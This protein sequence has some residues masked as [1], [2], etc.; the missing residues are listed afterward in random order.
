MSRRRLL[1][2]CLFLAF[3][4]SGSSGNGRGDDPPGPTAA[5]GAEPDPALTVVL[6][7]AQWERLPAVL[8]EL[9][10]RRPE[11]G[12]VYLA[13]PSVFSSP[14]A[15]VRFFG[16]RVGFA[17]PERVPGLD[18]KAPI[19]LAAFVPID[20]VEAQGAALVAAVAKKAPLAPSGVRHRLRLP[21]TDAKA[22]AAALE[23][24]LVAT[25][26]D[27]DGRAL[28]S[29]APGI[30]ADEARM[31]R[32]AAGAGAVDLTIVTGYG[33]AGL[34][35][36]A[37]D[38][39]LGAAGGPGAFHPLVADPTPSIARVHLRLDRFGPTGGSLGM[40]M[41]AR[42][43]FTMDDAFL[44]PAM[45]QG[46]AE[47]LTAPLF[48]DPTAAVTTDVIAD[49]PASPTSAPALY[50][51]L[52]ERGAT[53]LRADPGLAGGKPVALRT[54]DLPAI[55]AGAPLPPVIEA[56]GSLDGVVRLI[57]ECGYMCTLY[58]G[59]GNGLGLVRMAEAATPGI[60]KQGLAEASSMVPLLAN[61]QLTLAGSV[62]VV[63][64]LGPSEGAAERARRIQ[65]RPAA[66]ASPG[67]R[68]YHD[69]LAA[70]RKGF[71]AVTSADDAKA[72]PAMLEV[73]L[74]EQAANLTCAAKDPAFAA[75]A[76]DLR[77]LVEQLRALPAR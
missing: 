60:T 75:R 39:V 47:V 64:S 76:A 37:R 16:E 56:A 44:V 72:R 55:A 45:I 49:L 23:Q 22:L 20:S 77:K 12:A 59:L 70:V 67:H 71:M 38:R 1:V 42:A 41:I 13:G 14:W 2:P 48:A 21:A 27:D 54:V 3:A 50:V 36:A 18:D 9:V 15:V 40:M 65:P 34:D 35:A 7:P 24:A 66:T 69:A 26:P 52:T 46:Y 32:I 25:P 73:L 63:E 8:T 33:L 29:V 68:C 5:S 51:V 53:A 57:H 28:R 17:L 62:L 10:Q 4:C 6:Y 11:V 74:T 31:V 61:V 43:V 30:Y 19:V 58:G